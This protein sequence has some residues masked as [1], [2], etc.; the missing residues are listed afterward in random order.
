MRCPRCA[1]TESRVV[2]SRQGREGN[3]IRRR[4]E[5]EACNFRFSTRELLDFVLPFIVKRDGRRESYER[6]KVIAALRA[7]CQKRPVS[8]EILSAVAD[9]VELSLAAQGDREIASRHIGETLMDE[10]RTIDEAAWLR[11]ASVYHSFGSIHEFL[12]AAVGLRKEEDER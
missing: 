4:R 8:D 6:A 1:H 2:D 12:T 11:F 10:L 3:V 7:A 5:C 9:R